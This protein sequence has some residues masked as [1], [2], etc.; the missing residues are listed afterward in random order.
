MCLEE[1]QSGYK[2]KVGRD[3]KCSGWDG[4]EAAGLEP[5]DGEEA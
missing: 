2:T 1:E 3:L 5:W 4:G